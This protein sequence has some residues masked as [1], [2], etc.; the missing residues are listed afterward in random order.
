[1]QSMA[2]VTHNHN[3]NLLKG[4]V[5]QTAK[6]CRCREYCLSECLLYHVQVV[7][8]DVNQTKNSYGS[9][10]NIQNSSINYDLK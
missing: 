7:R 10:E 1:M 2:I 9:C 3:T 8:S 6:E 5:A 4:P